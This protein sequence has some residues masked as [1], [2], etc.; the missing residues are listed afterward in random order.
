M[1]D[2]ES[3]LASMTTTKAS[4]ED[5]VNI[6]DTRHIHVGYWVYAIIGF[7][8]LLFRLRRKGLSQR[9]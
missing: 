9:L 3:S 6:V 8:Q 1:M 7:S 2:V 4:D 5:I